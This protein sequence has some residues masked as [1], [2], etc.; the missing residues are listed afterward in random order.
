MTL[1]KGVDMEAYQCTDIKSQLELYGYCI[2]IQEAQTTDSG[3]KLYRLTVYFPDD[4]QV[5]FND[6]KDIQRFYTAVSSLFTAHTS[7]VLGMWF[8]G[9]SVEGDQELNRLIDELML[10]T[11]HLFNHSSFGIGEDSVA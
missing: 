8:R 9:G 6:I 7:K 11:I 5:V 2:Q 1:Y 3:A 10:N 4:T